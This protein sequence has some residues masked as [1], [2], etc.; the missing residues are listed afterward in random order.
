MPQPQR[1]CCQCKPS[2]REVPR[3]EFHPIRCNVEV[4]WYLRSRSSKALAERGGHQKVGAGS[5][6]PIAF[7]AAVGTFKSAERNINELTVSKHVGR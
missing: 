7:D 5:G 2:I 3:P 1:L 6:Q 4:S